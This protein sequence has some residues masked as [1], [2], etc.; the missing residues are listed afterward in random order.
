M[1]FDIL[2]LQRSIP[3]M[4]LVPMLLAGLVAALTYR[5]QPANLR[6][7]AWLLA[8]A[9]PLNL[10]GVVF[11]LQHRN[12]LFL[13]PIDLVGE[14]ALLAVIY[15]RTLQT[16]WFTRLLPV[17]IAGFAAYVGL[18]T[19]LGADLALFRPGPQVVGCLLQMLLVGLYYRKLL[20]ELHVTHLHRE[21][22]FWVSAGLLVYAAG[23]LQIALFSNFLL[24]YSQQLTLR[25]WAIN[26]LLFAALYC[27]YTRA[28]W[29][30]PRN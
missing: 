11:A 4:S 17:L 26:S 14:F 7:V 28:L 6:A 22:M 25:I 16:P 23:S 10:L 15:A 27:C 29:L 13:M 9:I 20:K 19:W 30:S 1:R 2:T 3:L 18:D 12:N 5:Q 8:F 24:H 21:P